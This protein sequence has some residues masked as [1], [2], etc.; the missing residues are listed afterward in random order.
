MICF[1]RNQ[2][3]VVMCSAVLVA[4]V[5]QGAA[6]AQTVSAGDLAAKGMTVTRI[7]NGSFGSLNSQMVFSTDGATLYVANYTKGV[8]A[9]DYAA[10]AL[11]NQRLIWANA[12]P[13]DAGVVGSLGV[14]VHHD[15]TLNKDVLYFPEAVTF[16]GGFNSG[17]NHRVQSLRRLADNDGDGTWGEAGELN[18]QILTNVQV[19][20]A[21]QINQVQIKGNSLYLSIGSQTVPG[22]NETAYT[23]NINWIQNVNTLG[24]GANA[25]GFDTPAGNGLGQDGYHLDK[26]PFTSTD[27]GKLRVWSTGMRNPFGVGFDGLNHNGDIWFSMN[28]QESPVQ[29]KPDEV[30]KSFYKAD[31]GFPKQYENQG[32]NSNDINQNLIANPGILFDDTVDWKTDADAIAAGFFNP[33][34]G[35]APIATS[36]ASLTGLEFIYSIDAALDGM[37]YLTR[38]RSLLEVNPNTGAL[39]TLITGF[40]SLA[41]DALRTPEGDL[42]IASG[43]DVYLVTIPGAIPI[44]E[45]TSMALISISGLLLL[46]RRCAA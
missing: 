7:A 10:G 17:G 44:P 5:C 22:N 31:H 14:A 25:A 38:G 12:S 6:S 28:Q 30:H 41:L 26:R 8:Y 34:N 39:R 37:M 43:D 11:S 2:Y 40:G 1:V 15:T 27:A 20:V 32:F 36:G 23:G 16:I 9:Y 19:T 42:L 18:Q 45:P 46:R 33:A 21:H 29:S 4:L 13:V 3:R 35:A 24:A